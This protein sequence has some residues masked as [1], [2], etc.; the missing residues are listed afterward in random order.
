MAAATTAYKQGRYADA[1]KS[2]Q[3]ALMEAEHP[4]KGDLRYTMTLTK[5]GDLAATLNNLASL[6]RKY[7][8]YT[9]AESLYKRSLVIWERILGPEHPHVA[10]SLEKYASL[11]R[12]AG[13]NPEAA[14]LE[15]RAKVI[16]TRK[17]Q[18]DSAR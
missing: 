15:A 2:L 14:R 18:R 3:A 8:N 16:R 7:V 6:N 4:G 17:G 10:V 11:L 9:K 12:E 5:L 13:R 1:E